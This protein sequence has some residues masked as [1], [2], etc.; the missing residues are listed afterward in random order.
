MLEPMVN[1]QSV[2]EPDRLRPFLERQR[3]FGGKARSIASVRLADALA[4]RQRGWLAVISVEFDRGDAQEYLLPLA[5]VEGSTAETVQ[6]EHP[7]A[8]VA[9]VEGAGMLVDGV[10]DDSLCV[11]LLEIIQGGQELRSGGGAWKPARPRHDARVEADHIRRTAPD[12]SNTSIVFGDAAILK[13]FRRVE[14][15]PNP[16]VEIGAFLTRLEFPQVPRTLGTLEYEREGEPPGAVAMLQEFVPNRG[17]GWEVMLDALASIDD[18]AR[19]P[20]RH[21]P[22]PADDLPALLGRRTGELHVHLARGE[23]ES[24]VPEP[25]RGAVLAHAAEEMRTRVQAH[26]DLLSLSLARLDEA[27]RGQAVQVLE[28]RAALVDVFTTMAALDDAG[29]RIRCH[30]DYHLGQTLVTDRDVVILDFEGEPAR[31]LAERRIKSS[32]LR[33]VAGM[34]RSFSYAATA[35]AR[36]RQSGAAAGTFGAWQAWE[37]SAARLFVSAY[38]D[39]VA[40]ARILPA[41]QRDVDALLR[42]Y[43]VD[44]AIYEVGYELNNRPDWVAIPLAGVLRCLDA[45]LP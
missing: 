37:A 20:N 13:L 18:A 8:I 9:P 16:D 43:V 10:F 6:R 38:L 36:S 35:A 14:T 30:G 7:D 32:P 44:K 11:A 41:Q 40:H 26:L 31:P 1:I 2:L 21:S 3:W 33:D 39:A 34:L 12:Q 5:V 42:A 27:T 23:D 22:R 25:F 29:Q 15:G 45:R 19:D 24:F 28:S 4:V 17:N